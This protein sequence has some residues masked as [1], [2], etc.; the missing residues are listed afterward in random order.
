MAE[1]VTVDDA[2]KVHAEMQGKLCSMLYA[3]KDTSLLPQVDYAICVV[4]VA[5]TSATTEKF[6]RAMTQLANLYCGADDA[7][8]YVLHVYADCNNLNISF[9]DTACAVALVERIEV[10]GIAPFLRACAHA[11]QTPQCNMAYVYYDTAVEMEELK[12]TVVM[13]H[14]ISLPLPEKTHPQ[15]HQLLRICQN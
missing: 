2:A 10:E 6:T 3:V 13:G 11:F 5:P 12:H 9:A 4:H 1:V 8:L 7:P 15:L 14:N